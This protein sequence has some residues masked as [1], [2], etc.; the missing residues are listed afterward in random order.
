MCSIELLYEVDRK[1]L[2]LF[3]QL[4]DNIYKPEFRK[5]IKYDFNPYPTILES[6]HYFEFACPLVVQVKQEHDST[7]YKE[8]YT[9]CEC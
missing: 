3:N 2:F 6:E 8:Y 5:I 9:I 7:L 4:E 1:K